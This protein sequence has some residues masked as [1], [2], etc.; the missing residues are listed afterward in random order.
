MFPYSFIY[1][2][3]GYLL[4]GK[5][6]RNQ[7]IQCFPKSQTFLYLLHLASLQSMSES[8]NCFQTHNFH[9]QWCQ[10]LF[11]TMFIQVIQPNNPAPQPPLL[12]SSQTDKHLSS[13][14]IQMHRDLISTCELS[15]KLSWW[16]HLVYISLELD[17]DLQQGCCLPQLN[18]AT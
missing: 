14:Q 16:V 11:V 15:A 18:R 13:C 17:H 8:E 6:R 12:P 5:D 4:P 2:F 10:C 3:G 9:T 1:L 7:G